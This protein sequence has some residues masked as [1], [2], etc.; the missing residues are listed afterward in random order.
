MNLTVINQITNS[1][2]IGGSEFQWNCYGENARFLD[3]SS[4]FADLTVVFDSN[5]QLIYEATIVSRSDDIKPYRWVNPDYK[6]ALM[7]ESNEKSVNF[8]QAF[9]TDEYVDLETSEDF[10]D[11][12]EAIF[13]GKD[14]DPR[15]Q[16]PLDLSNDEW[17]QLM[18]I[19]HEKDITLNQLVTDILNEFITNK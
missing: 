13:N 9:D 12:A 10:L 11:K 15:V 8:A 18:K 1:K 7:N 6:Q 2:I 5:D 4:D 14:F 19:A 16:L 17:F 3:Y